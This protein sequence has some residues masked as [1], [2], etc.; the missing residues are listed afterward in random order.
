MDLG[1]ADRRFVGLAGE[2]TV[3]E[4]QGISE[5]MYLIEMVDRASVSTV[6]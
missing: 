1:A 2:G 5:K 4:A 6:N 3:N